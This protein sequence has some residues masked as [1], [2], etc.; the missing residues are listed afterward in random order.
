MTNDNYDTYC[1]L[2]CGAC[3]I[4]KAHRTGRATP[5][6][7]FWNEAIVRKF[8]DR[9]GVPEGARRPYSLECHGCKSDMLFVNCEACGIRKCAVGK[10]VE[11]CMECAEYPCKL[12]Q[13]LAR[14]ES[15][16]PH[17]KGKRANMDAIRARGAD[18]WLREQEAAWKCPD[19]GAAFSWYTRRCDSCGRDL[20]EH[21]YKFSRI[22]SLL[23]RLSIHLMPKQKP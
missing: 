22:K 21:T 8:L 16:L 7:S 15:V 2:Y 11:R 18:A 1:G 23:L 12:I 19:C 4:L 17:L 6:S 14:A 10:N 9:L 5:L 13:D 20:S 3:D